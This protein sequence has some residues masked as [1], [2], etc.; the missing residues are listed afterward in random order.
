MGLLTRIKRRIADAADDLFDGPDRPAGIACTGAAL[1][2]VCGGARIPAA[3]AACDTKIRHRRLT[4][5]ERRFAENVF[6]GSL[7][8]ND[9]IV[10]TNLTGLGARPFTCPNAAG[11]TLVNVGA[12]F[13]DPTAYESPAY[14]APGKLLVHELT[15]VWQIRH[16]AFFPGLVCNA[17]VTHLTDGSY[18]PGEGGKPW[19]EYN[20]EQQATIVDEWFAPSFRGPAGYAAMSPDHPYHRYVVGTIRR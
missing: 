16:T 19:D 4:D 6:G 2:V 15:H 9:R 17:L 14:P 7:P 5:G 8:P 10:L 1:S 13:D 12:A 11:Q 18:R 3:L 20:L